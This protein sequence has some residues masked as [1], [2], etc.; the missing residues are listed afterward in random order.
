MAVDNPKKAEVIE[1]YRR[2][3]SDNGSTEVQ[4]AILTQRI[5]H[6]TAHLKQFPKDHATR[7][8]LLQLV[9]RRSALVRY[10]ARHNPTGYKDLIGRLGIRR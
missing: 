3:E 8:G 2:H 7:R 6:L 10:L 9:G 5:R 1:Q 4:V